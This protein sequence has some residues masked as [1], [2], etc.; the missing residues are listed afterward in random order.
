VAARG[1]RPGTRSM[2]SDQVVAIKVVQH[3]HVERGG[4]RPILLVAPHVDVG[5]VGSAI[6]EPVDQPRVPVKGEDHGPVGGEQGVELGVG[7]P[8]GC[9]DSGR[10]RIRSTTFKNRTDRSGRC[11]WIRSAAAKASRVGVSPAQARITLGSSP[12]VSVLAQ[13]QMPIPRVQLAT[14]SSMHKKSRAGCLP[15][16]M[17]LT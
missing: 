3:H 2:T 10:S 14:A 15:A 1:S 12:A 5:V 11:W 13:S 9:S 16:T 6:G 17:T 8:W 4:G 7:K